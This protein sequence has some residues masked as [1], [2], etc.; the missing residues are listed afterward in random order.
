MADPEAIFAYKLGRLFGRIDWWRLKDEHSPY[1]WQ[2]QKAMA[3]V[4]P[5]GEDRADWRNAVATSWICASNGVSVSE[6]DFDSIRH[7]LPVN[8]HTP[9]V[10]PAGARAIVEG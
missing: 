8:H 2:L 10:G 7:Y 4:E 3:H 5:S 1:E 6:D 9:T